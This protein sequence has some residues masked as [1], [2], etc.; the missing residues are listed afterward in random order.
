M[1]VNRAYE[2]MD[3]YI[4][5]H[6]LNKVVCFMCT[7]DT[8]QFGAS[9]RL[10]E[11]LHRLDVRQRARRGR[12]PIV[13]TATNHHTNAGTVLSSEL[14]GTRFGS[15]PRYDAMKRL[16]AVRLSLLAKDCVHVESSHRSLRAVTLWVCHGTSKN[17]I[18]G[19]HLNKEVSKSR[20]VLRL[21]GLVNVV[22]DRKACISCVHSNATLKARPGALPKSPLHVTLRHHVFRA[23]HRPAAC[24]SL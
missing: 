5:V 23:V 9:L 20:V 24:V 6:N 3:P 16:I 13:Q 10:E 21:V 19:L 15:R 7:L 18:L 2:S 12:D 14:I 8:D 4:I 1:R 17:K 22:R 11:P